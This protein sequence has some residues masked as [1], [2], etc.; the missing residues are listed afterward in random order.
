M[1]VVLTDAVAAPGSA[2]DSTTDMASVDAKAKRV[3]DA[4]YPSRLQSD[5]RAACAAGA[6]ALARWGRKT[7]QTQCRLAYGATSRT[8]MAC[9]I[10]GAVGEDLAANA[11]DYE[12]R[13]ASC[14]GQY[15]A[16]TEVDLYLQE[17]CL[18]GVY[19]RRILGAT[20]A[21][22]CREITPERSFLGPCEAGANLIGDAP[23]SAA[24]SSGTAAATKTVADA[25]PTAE[26]NPNSHNRLCE[27]YF[28]HRQLHL[29]YRACLNARGV[30]AAGSKG[31]S[32]D[33]LS[34]CDQLV[35]DAKNDLERA[36]CVVGAS[37]YRNLASGLPTNPRF[38]KCGSAKVSYQD[39]D[40]LPC[41]VAASF[42]DFGD[43]KDAEKGCKSLFV[44]KRSASKGECDRA[45][46]QF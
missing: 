24:V 39:R 22:Q 28:D 10:G 44:G 30:S 15:P 11:A 1:T 3:C 29:G 34:A 12:A 27:R 23:A 18:T 25:A 14:A 45:V 46:S 26:L 4:H 38:E 9:L 31:R 33:V 36:A 7:A 42:L 40:S 6:Q 8:T 16:H 41:L 35:S 19:M 43:K 21:R 17:S 13:R 20:D 5:V 37:I 32:A 2:P